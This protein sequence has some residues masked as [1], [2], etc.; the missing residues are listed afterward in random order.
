MGMVLVVVLADAVVAVL[1]ASM[2]V[3]IA[4]WTW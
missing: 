3:I 1:F 4:A 2:V